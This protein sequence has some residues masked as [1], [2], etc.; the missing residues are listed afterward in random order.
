MTRKTLLRWRGGNLRKKT[1]KNELVNCKKKTWSKK[2][3][4]TPLEEWEWAQK[5]RK[6]LDESSQHKNGKTENL[7]DRRKNNFTTE[8]KKG[9][10]NRMC[11]N[12]KNERKKEGVKSRVTFKWKRNIVVDLGGKKTGEKWQ[13][14]LNWLR[15]VNWG[16]EGHKRRTI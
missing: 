9:G 7:S 12:Q 11:R 13:R 10:N 6:C 1:F 5:G 15:I 4:W 3:R 8:I 14:L 16:Q 2:E